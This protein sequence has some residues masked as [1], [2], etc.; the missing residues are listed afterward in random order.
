MQ[1]QI[2]REDAYNRSLGKV[3]ANSTT[4][5]QLSDFA[6]FGELVQNAPTSKAGIA[7]AAMNLAAKGA[8]WAGR[9]PIQTAPEELARQLVGQAGKLS[10]LAPQAGKARIK[11]SQKALQKIFE[12]YLLSPAFSAGFRTYS[13]D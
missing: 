12:D 8:R 4:A 13:A 7:R 3:G 5:E 1:E 6:N 11:P 2:A 10:K 9:S